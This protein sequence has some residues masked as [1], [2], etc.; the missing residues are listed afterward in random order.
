MPVS[1]AIINKDGEKA[2]INKH[3]EK[4]EEHLQV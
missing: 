1:T 4:H 2:I 3:G